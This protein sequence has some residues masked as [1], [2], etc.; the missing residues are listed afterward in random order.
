[1]EEYDFMC[2]DSFYRNYFLKKQ[3]AEKKNI[4]ELFGNSYLWCYTN[5]GFWKAFEATQKHLSINSGSQ[6]K[7][8]AI[9]L[10]IIALP[11]WN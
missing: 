5:L 4:Y 9:K 6:Q 3:S 8:C 2:T 10:Q 1:M 7:M 11:Q